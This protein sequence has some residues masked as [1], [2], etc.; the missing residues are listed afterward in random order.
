MPGLTKRS[1]ICTPDGLTWEVPKHSVTLSGTSPR[2]PERA[3]L[4]RT[5]GLLPSIVFPRPSTTCWRLTAALRKGAFGGLPSRETLPEAI[6]P[7]YSPH[8][9]PPTP[10][11]QRRLLLASPH[12]RRLPI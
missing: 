1:S 8:A 4:S 7:W 11:P 6:S 12:H 5:I 10:S 9:Y 3:H 2:G